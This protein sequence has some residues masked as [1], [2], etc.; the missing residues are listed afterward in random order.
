MAGRH[1]KNQHAA[2]QNLSVAPQQ[3]S[4]VVVIHITIMHD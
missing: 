1:Q 2:E 4:V 3:K